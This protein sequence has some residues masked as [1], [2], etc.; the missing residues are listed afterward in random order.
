MAH[1][2]EWLVV[3]MVWPENRDGV[4]SSG[5]KEGREREGKEW[6]G[7]VGKEHSHIYTLTA[8][9]CCWAMSTSPP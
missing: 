8:L 3:V 9:A 2:D 7:S 1:F 5:G 6:K 4:R